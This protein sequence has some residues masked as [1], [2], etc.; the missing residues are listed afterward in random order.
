MCFH[1]QRSAFSFTDS[2]DLP[3]KT[4]SMFYEKQQQ[5]HFM[6]SAVLKETPGQTDAMLVNPYSATVSTCFPVCFLAFFYSPESHY[7][8]EEPSEADF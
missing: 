5:I 6:A 8:V 2:S 3:P 1:W 4:H 7:A